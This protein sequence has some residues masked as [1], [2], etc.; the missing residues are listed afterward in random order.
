MLW[1]NKTPV[2]QKSALVISQGP[3]QPQAV[4]SG[5]RNFSWTDHCNSPEF[6]CVWKEPEHVIHALENY[7]KPK[8][9]TSEKQKQTKTKKIK[10]KIKN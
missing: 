2:N 9:R 3:P 4:I 7:T 5:G 10:I 6:G 1:D 8:R